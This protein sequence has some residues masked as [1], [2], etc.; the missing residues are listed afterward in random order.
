M[1][2]KEKVRV[3]NITYSSEN[4]VHTSQVL[5]RFKINSIL[6]EPSIEIKR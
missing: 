4:P 5:I 2:G 3:G 1:N 6:F